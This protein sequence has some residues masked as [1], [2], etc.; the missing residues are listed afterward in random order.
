M[1]RK[2]LR[3]QPVQERSQQRI[4]RILDAADE[5]FAEVGYEQATTNAIAARAEASIGSLY[6]FFDDKHAILEA[7]ARRYKDQLH[8]VHENVLTPE[9]ARLPLPEIYDRILRALADFHARNRGFRPLF[10]GSATAGELAAAGEALR[11]ECIGRVEQMLAVRAPGLSP[12]R[13]KLLATINV[14]VTRA[15]L[16]LSESGDSR[17][18]ESMLGEI[19]KLLLGYMEQAVGDDER[20]GVNRV[21]GTPG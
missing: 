15:L 2:A 4:T 7:L 12:A 1:V 8:A 21:A 17:F 14:E 19:K 16:P 10:H 9:T 6:Q 20:R 5:L 3:R 18:R 13:R 11:Q